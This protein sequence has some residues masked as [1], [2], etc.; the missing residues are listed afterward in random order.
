MTSLIQ[1]SL[2]GAGVYFDYENF[3]VLLKQS[4]SVNP[5]ELNFFEV[6]L[7]RLRND[8]RL[9]II[10]AIA[11][12]NFE[13]R[14]LSYHQSILQ[15]MGVQTRHTANNGKN[16]GD[17]E[18]TVDA[19][20]SLFKNEAITVFVIVSSDRD[21]IPLL[22][23]IKYENRKSHVISTRNGFNGSAICYADSHEYIED[24][25]NLKK[26]VAPANEEFHEPD[27]LITDDPS[28][29]DLERCEQIISLL[30]ASIIWQKH[31]TEGL[32]VT[33]KGFSEAVSRRVQRDPQQII[34]EL[35]LAHMLS[36]VEIYPHPD[37]GLCL[38]RTN[39]KIGEPPKNQ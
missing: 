4:Y 14:D 21:I 20:K 38:R 28:H 6:I 27:I 3:F 24:I 9:N 18:L 19:L 16:S 34:K 15:K 23:A 25:F 5:L 17:L 11:Y 7:N 1:S 33:L 12:S 32:P 13:R 10:E 37:K 26:S 31:E 39:V 8:F 35:H 22:K 2:T 36:L 30:F 29:M